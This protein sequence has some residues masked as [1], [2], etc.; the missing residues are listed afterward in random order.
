MV[1][2]ANP[3]GTTGTALA[4][5][6]ADNRC[7]QTRHHRQIL[8]D[9]FADTALLGVNTRIRSRRIYQG[10]NWNF[11]PLSQ[12]HQ[13][14]GL[15]VPLWFWHA[16][17]T[18]DLILHRPPLLLTNHHHRTAI[19]AGKTPNNRAVIGEVA[20][21]VQFIELGKNTRDIVKCVGAL[22]MARH[23]DD[24]PG[25]EV[26]VDFLSELGAFIPQILDL[27]ANIDL[28]IRA[29]QSQLFNLNFQLGDRLLKV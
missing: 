25:T 13:A 21:A 27:G 3:Q 24:I 14:Q 18:H 11:V 28:V 16:K 15:A 9:R 12:L 23:F 19:D 6:N 4:N 29:N 5:H 7:R 10:N 26:R 8:G 1:A 22:W 20:V 2:H 17:I